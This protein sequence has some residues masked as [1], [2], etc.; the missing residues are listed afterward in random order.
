MAFSVIELKNIH[1]VVGG[2]CKRRS[3]PDL[4]NK[5]RFTYEIREHDVVIYESRARFN[6]P[7]EWSKMPC[8][9][10]KYSRSSRKW[11]L[12]WMRQDEKWYPY[13]TE[14]KSNELDALGAEIESDRNGA[15]FG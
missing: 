6:K 3:P 4:H 7:S 13:K 9:K 5:I 11:K 12:Y 1:K 14:T 2:I 10:L 15:F 8:A